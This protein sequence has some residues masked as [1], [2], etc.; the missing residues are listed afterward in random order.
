[1][2]EAIGLRIYIEY[3]DDFT[4]RVILNPEG[5]SSVNPVGIW[6][7]ASYLVEHQMIDVLDAGGGTD[8]GDYLQKSFTGTWTIWFA[9]PTEGTWA[10][11]YGEVL[12][13][14]EESPGSFVPYSPDVGTLQWLY[15]DAEDVV[16][17]VTP[18][19]GFTNEGSG[20][21]VVLFYAPAISPV[22]I[23]AAP[24]PIE[25]LKWRDFIGTLEIL[26]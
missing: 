15:R 9:P 10:K 7:S 11:A 18:A 20:G 8:A 5:V 13:Y 25:G 21:T 23:F 17:A 6:D 22:L 19:G 4:I 26:P 1:M 16:T 14:Y 12:C 2:A 3:E 24:S